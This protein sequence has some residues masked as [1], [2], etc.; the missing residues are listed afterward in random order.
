M[1][2]TGYSN[3]PWYVL[4]CVRS[5]YSYPLPPVISVLHV[6]EGTEFVITVYMV[7]C[8]LYSVVCI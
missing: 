1:Y 3:Q 5:N 8:L 4:I 7:F 2:S 6:R